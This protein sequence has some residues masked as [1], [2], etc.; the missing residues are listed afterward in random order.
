MTESHTITLK[1]KR[2]YNFY[3]NHPSI[4]FEE[5]NNYMVDLLEKMMQTS[6]PNLDYNLASKLLEQMNKVHSDIT[7][8]QC[9]VQISMI[10]KLNELKKDYLKD[11]ELVLSNNNTEKL[12]PLLQQQSSVL[13]DKVKLILQDVLPQTQSMLKQ[14]METSVKHLYESIQEETNQLLEK[15]IDKKT[16][17]EFANTIDNKFAKSLVSS[18]TFLNNMMSSTEQRITKTLGDGQTIT[19]NRMQSMEHTVNN[20]QQ[21]QKNLQQNVSE[22][23]RKMDNSSSKGKISENLLQ[24]ILH[25]AYPSAQIDFVGTTKETG[26]I[27]MY[28][29]NK[30]TILFENKNYERNV[31]QD[32]VKKFI[33]DIEV[34]QCSGILCAQ[35]YGIANK[36]NYQIDIHNGHV[37]VYVHKMDYDPER[38]KIAVDMIDHFTRTIE[39]LDLGNESFQLDK[40]ALHDINKEYQA[41]VQSKSNQI[42]MVKEYNQK[43]LAQ[44]EE[45]KLPQLEALLSKFFITAVAKENVC[46]YCNYIAKNP[47]ALIAHHRGCTEKKRALSM[48]IEIHTGER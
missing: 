22:L 3:K 10:E 28:R 9:N 21:E 39:E 18:Q 15:T 17:E 20:T 12:N 19:S 46:E 36:G 32:E 40:Q 5:T 37:L 1:N 6:Q 35:T 24:H 33:R 30:P 7:E 16:L 48:A 41:F 34:Q 47:R 44:L 25:R 27:V 31:G 11:F 8:S 13:E 4:S 43:L 23:L 42:K 26:D 2:I 14:D 38:L 45:W 29:E